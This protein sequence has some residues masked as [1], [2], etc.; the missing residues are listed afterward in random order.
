MDGI[1]NAAHTHTHTIGGSMVKIIFSSMLQWNQE[2][3]IW[4]VSEWRER[5][6]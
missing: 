5:Q 3:K 6:Q 4:Y 1:L 2:P